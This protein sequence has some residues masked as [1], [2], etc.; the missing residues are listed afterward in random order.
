MQFLRQLL[1][2]NTQYAPLI[3]R[4]PVGVILMAHGAQKLFG[5]FG[6]GGLEGTGKWMASIG[7][8]PGMLMAALA[9][10]GEFFG[11]LFLLLGLL[12]RPAACVTAFTMVVAIFSVHINNGLFLS[13]NGYEYALA[14]LAAC[15]SL[16]FSGSGKVSLDQAILRLI[17]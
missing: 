17:K 9:G 13:N 10:S 7:I 3:L 15:T 4:V 2:S 1:S 8:E 16:I 5:W 6:G 14:L 12:T 11:G